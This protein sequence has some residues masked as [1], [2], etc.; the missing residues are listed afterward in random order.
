MNAPSK[1]QASSQDVAVIPT[2]TALSV[3]TDREQFDAFYERVRAEVEAHVPDVTTD[4]GRKAIASLA[5]K[6]ART[7]TAIDEAGKLL[8]EE[9]RRQIE[10]VN[11]SRREIR[12]RLDALKDEARRPLTEWEDAEARHQEQAREILQTINRLATTSLEDSSASVTSRILELEEIDLDEAVM[13]DLMPVASAALAKGIEAL[14]VARKRLLQEE[15]DRAELERLRREAAEREA[16]LRAEMERKAA[17]EAEARAQAEAQAKAEREEQE[18]REAEARA[19]EAA[20]ERARLE[21]EAKARAEQ[22][23]MEREHAARLD[24]ERRAR[25]QAEAAIRAEREARE[26]EAA[27]AQAR[28][29]AEAREKARREADI[30]HKSAVLRTAKEALIEHAG[31]DEPQAKAAIQAIAARL[32]PQV[33]ITF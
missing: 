22:E 23:A 8:T 15:A 13:R 5:Y 18:R 31:L 33:A 14:S 21:A 3:L 7:K 16:A 27:E 24:A 25:E 26:R 19:A 9:A 28:A 10:R 30:A 1:T 20:A 11:D 12:E 2:E 6:V 4:K 17:A 29:D 32:V